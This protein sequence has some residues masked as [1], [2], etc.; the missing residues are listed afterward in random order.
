MNNKVWILTSG[1]YSDYA[2]EGVFSTKEKAEIAAKHIS[3]ANEPSEMEIDAQEAIIE[4]G[5]YLV[6]MYADGNGARAEI[7]Q[8]EEYK[9]G[10]KFWSNGYP[11]PRRKPHCCSGLVQATSP[12][13]AIKILNE[14]RIEHIAN[15]G[16]WQ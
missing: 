13:H 8:G 3:E 7:Y 11:K 9:L 1:R 10:V 5:I 2:V 6:S 15:N 12:E 16:E 14:K 4:R